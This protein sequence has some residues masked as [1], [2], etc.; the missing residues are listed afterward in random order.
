MKS[1]MIEIFRQHTKK[2][3]KKYKQKNINEFNFVTI[4]NF[5]YMRIYI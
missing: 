2:N 4:M 1:K 3:T 5:F